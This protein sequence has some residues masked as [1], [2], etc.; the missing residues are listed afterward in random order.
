MNQYYLKKQV[1]HQIVFFV[2]C[3]YLALK[4]FLDKFPHSLRNQFATFHWTVNWMRV[5]KMYAV[6]T[7]VCQPSGIYQFIKKI[8]LRGKQEETVKEE[9]KKKLKKERKRK[10]E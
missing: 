4:C 8:F 6:V 5:L 7:R 2:T 9:R 3:N 1:L 10:K